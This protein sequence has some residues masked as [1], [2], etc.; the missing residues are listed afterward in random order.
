[1]TPVTQASYRK[2]AAH[3]YENRL[4]GEPITP[5]RITDAL[6]AC[7]GDYRPDYWR[8]LRNALAF[9]QREK[10]FSDAANRIDGTK[11]PSTKEGGSVKAKQPRTRRVV[12]ADQ[13]KL[14]DALSKSGDAQTYA[15]VVVSKITG[16][17][18]AELQGIEIREGSVFIPGAKQS[19]GGMRGADRLIS[20]SSDDLK[21]LET[22]LPMLQGAN[23]GAIQDRLRAAGKRLWPQRKSVPSLYSW[24]HQLGSDLKASGMPRDQVAFVMGHQSTSSVDKYGNRMMGNG[25]RVLPKPAADADLSRVRVDHTEPPAPAAQ[26]GRSNDLPATTIETIGRALGGK[27]LETNTSPEAIRK[28]LGQGVSKTRGDD[29]LQP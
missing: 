22:A 23:V 10:G 9:D 3:F 18:P 17:R 26:V 6:K 2:L 12:D 5:K 27:G 21:A 19:H 7:A 29:G 8:K 25:G 28:A 20:V 11:N 4:S 15:A 13:S 14:L 24:R 1:M 16:A